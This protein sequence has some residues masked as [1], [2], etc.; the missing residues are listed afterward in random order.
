VDAVDL[1]WSLT[2]M[3]ARRTL[4]K[5]CSHHQAGKLTK[6]GRARSMQ[7]VIRSGKSIAAI[8]PDYKLLDYDPLT[9][10][11]IHRHPTP[12]L[13]HT[14]S[15]P[16]DLSSNGNTPPPNSSH[17]PL[18]RGLSIVLP[19]EACSSPLPLD[20]IPDWHWQATRPHAVGGPQVE[21]RI[22]ASTTH[23]GSSAAACRL[24]GMPKIDEGQHNTPA[25]GLGVP[26]ATKTC[27]ERTSRHKG[28]N[29][30]LSTFTAGVVVGMVAAWVLLRRG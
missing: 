11:Y 29:V 28:C 7:V 1:A 20:P 18:V 25:T 13:S 14:V 8:P 24:P 19:S 23:N 22:H 21:Q 17:Q 3:Q 9:R 16:P 10:E 27:D 15:I 4:A 6:F 30:M 5:P 2:L 12:T 26:V